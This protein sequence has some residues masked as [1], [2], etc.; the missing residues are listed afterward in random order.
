MKIGMIFTHIK[1]W[2]NWAQG[3]SVIQGTREGRDEDL[4]SPVLRGPFPIQ[5]IN[6]Y[7]DRVVLQL[8]SELVLTVNK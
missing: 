8:L 1:N 2:G 7:L 5:L 4:N 6:S 3:Q